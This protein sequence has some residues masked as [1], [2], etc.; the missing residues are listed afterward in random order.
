MSDF[1]EAMFLETDPDGI[2]LCAASFTLDPT[3]FMVISSSVALP[4]GEVAFC[5][6]LHD[7]PF[8][9]N[10]DLFVGVAQEPCSISTGAMMR[11]YPFAALFPNPTDGPLLLELSN[12]M[13][14]PLDFEITDVS[15]VSCRKGALRS[16]QVVDTDGLK[17][18]VYVLRLRDSLGSSIATRF[19][20]R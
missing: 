12:R 7:Y 17:A 10:D 4:N 11:E 19:V 18:G 13:R 6:H 8:I 9:E 2:P 3:K 15:G 14:W 1:P 16:D 5:G 20:R